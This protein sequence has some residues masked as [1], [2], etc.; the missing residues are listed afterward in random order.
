MASNDCNGSNSQFAGEQGLLCPCGGQRE[1]HC[2][3]DK[4]LDIY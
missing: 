4:L 1:R 2:W 3:L